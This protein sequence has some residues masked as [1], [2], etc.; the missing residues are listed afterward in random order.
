MDSQRRDAEIGAV[1]R[2][3]KA[4]YRDPAQSAKP[5][6]WQCLLF[7]MLTARTT[8]DQVEP[9]FAAL[10]RAYPSPAALAKAKVR[11][12]ERII[13][14]IGLYKTKAKNAIALAKML[15]E[16]FNGVVPADL[17]ALASLPGVGRKTASCV[18]VYSFGIPAIPVDTHVLRIV[19]RLGWVRA[20]TP[21]K[22]E[23]ALRN[24]VA[25]RHWLDLNRVM[26]QFGRD[27]C[28]APKPKCWQCPVRAECAF[29]HKT[30]AP[31][32]V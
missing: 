16:Q 21:E 11:D 30:S 4:K 32:S 17:D 31:K 6:A 29:P 26:V 1:M 22:T 15:V 12:V 13:K 28:T 8:D 19:N 14:T 2:V 10:M 18:L 20:A 23:R 27:I 25:K 7:T 3:L 24:V 5:D 9:V